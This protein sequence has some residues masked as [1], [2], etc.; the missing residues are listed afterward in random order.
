MT[1]DAVAIQV[2]G[3]SYSYPDGSKALQEV[4]F[5][6]KRGERVGFVGANG[7]GKSTLLLHLNGILQGKGVTIVG[8]AVT[9]A[10]LKSVRQKVGL[11]FQ[12]PD[13]QLFCPTV[14]E[15]IAFGLRNLR[16]PEDEVGRRVRES[17]RTVGLEG[18]EKRSAFHLSVGQKKRIALATVLAMQ[19]DILV[20][21][22]PTSNLD[23]RG[24]REI[25]ALLEQLGGTQVIATHDLA[26]VRKLC[27][28]VIVL[29]EGGIVA[30][31]EPRTILNDE[32]FLRAHDLS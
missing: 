18:F 24:R 19:C 2:T 5:Q 9:K 12:N 22:E 29:R 32:A 21:D 16:I 14:F 1:A 27:S 28:R 7:A 17:L 15:D 26:L 11:V 3:L 4:S 31:G 10:N 23:P 6:V 25:A 8:M 13:D 20:L 30:D